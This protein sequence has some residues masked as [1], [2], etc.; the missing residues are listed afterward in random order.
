MCIAGAQGGI[1]I[2]RIS[3]ELRLRL[4][5]CDYLHHAVHELKTSSWV[6]WKLVRG[7]GVNLEGEQRV[8]DCIRCTIEGEGGYVGVD[9]SVEVGNNPPVLKV[10]FFRILSHSFLG[11]RGGGNSRLGHF[12]HSGGS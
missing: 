5:G 10:G 3:S 7:R 6:R 8:A 4:G 1:D 12:Y 9:P 11:F 2:V